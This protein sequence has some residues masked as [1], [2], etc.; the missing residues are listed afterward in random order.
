MSAVTS[1]FV[2]ISTCHQDVI[3]RVMKGEFLALHVETQDSPE[4]SRKFPLYLLT[5]YLGTI[6]LSLAKQ[7]P[8]IHSVLAFLPQLYTHQSPGNGMESS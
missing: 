1:R 4:R 8:G 3:D 6:D 2:S 5:H 7:H